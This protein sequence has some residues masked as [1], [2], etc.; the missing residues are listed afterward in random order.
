MEPPTNRELY[1]IAGGLLA[2]VVVMVVCQ[3]LAF[4]DDVKNLLKRKDNS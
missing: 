2:L 4:K 3:I 1:F